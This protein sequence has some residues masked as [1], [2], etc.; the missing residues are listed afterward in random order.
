M[1]Y[2][3]LKSVATVAFFIVWIWLISS[4][5]CDV[6]PT[7]AVE[8][9]TTEGVSDI[10]LKGHGYGDCDEHGHV[11]TRFEGVKAGHKI[12]GTL[13]GTTSSGPFHIRYK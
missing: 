12:S 8:L 10:V 13:C 9:L 4:G 5:S 1:N 2:D 7:K 11:S 3:T 6:P